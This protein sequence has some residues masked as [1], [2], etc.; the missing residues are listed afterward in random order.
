MRARLVFLIAIVLLVAGFT[1][2]NWTEILRTAP[3]SFGWRVIEAP[4]GLILLSLMGALLVAFLVG[5]AV[6][7]S[8]ILLQT[9]HHT[10]TLQAQRDLAERAEASRYTE[11][12]KQLDEHLRSNLEREAI[13]ATE[14]E[15]SMVQSQRE[16]RNQL[17][18][19]NKTLASR[20]DAFEGRFAARLDERARD[21]VVIA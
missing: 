14:F 11:L 4:L 8:D 18:L 13:A 15:K 21:N 10:K 12:R 6:Q 19:M 5:S 20:L 17:D 2:M 3:L 16:L 7:Q 9:H 1:A